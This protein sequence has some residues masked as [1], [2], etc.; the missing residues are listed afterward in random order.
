MKNNL[1]KKVKSSEKKA[2]KAMIKKMEEYENGGNE[3]YSPEQQALLLTCLKMDIENIDHPR[4]KLIAELCS[5]IPNGLTTDE[6]KH[7]VSLL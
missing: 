3:L 1:T 6:I 2:K 4:N 5:L 7:I